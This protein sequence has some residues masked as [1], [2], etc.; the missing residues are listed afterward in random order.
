MWTLLLL[1]ATV[2]SFAHIPLGISDRNTFWL[3]RVSGLAMWRNNNHWKGHIV[4]A[5]TEKINW[6]SFYCFCFW[7][8]MM[9]A[10]HFWP[11]CCTF[12]ARG[13]SLVSFFK[14]PL[15]KLALFAKSE[16]SNV[17]FNLL[18]PMDHLQKNIRWTTLLC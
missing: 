8:D 12:L 10:R 11:F 7:S 2:R 1:A 17:V 18:R 6:L 14:I 13:W 16:I 3:L 5:A 15:D 4:C 9:E